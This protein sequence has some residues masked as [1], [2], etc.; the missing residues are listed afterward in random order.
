M[1]VLYKDVIRFVWQI[2]LIEHVVRTHPKPETEAKGYDVNV[3]K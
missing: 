3:R 2:Y 1:A